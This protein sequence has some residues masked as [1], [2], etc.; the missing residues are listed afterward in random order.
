MELK[1]TPELKRVRAQVIAAQVF[2]RDSIFSQ[3]MQ[4]GSLETAGYA[5]QSIDTMLRKLQEVTAE[6]VQAVAQKYL[7]DDSL[8]IAVLDPQPL[9]GR[10][11]AAQTQGVRPVQ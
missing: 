8:S 6:Q 5:H 10:K 11:P 1:I 9:D 3:A 7:V 2:Q 4:I